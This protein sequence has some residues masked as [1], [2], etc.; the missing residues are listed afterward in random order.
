MR[1]KTSLYHADRWRSSSAGA[2]RRRRLDTNPPS[3]KREATENGKKFF[4]ARLAGSWELRVPKWGKN[5]SHDAMEGHS[6]QRVRRRPEKKKKF[7]GNV[8]VQN[9]RKGGRTI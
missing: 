9:D 2:M 7:C 6:N 5:M 1:G 8:R 4:K 3:V